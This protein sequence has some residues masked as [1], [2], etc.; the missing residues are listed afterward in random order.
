MIKKQNGFTLIEILVVIAIICILAA[1]L[2]INL[3]PLINGSKEKTSNAKIL[4]MAKSL[5]S[6]YADHSRYPQDKSSFSSNVF[7]SELKGDPLSDPPKKEYYP[8]KSHE[9]GSNGEWM[10]HLGY[11]YY[12]RNNQQHNYSSR[13]PPPPE[14]RNIT[15]YD[16]WSKDAHTPEEVTDPIQISLKTKV[17]NWD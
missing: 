4:E 5:E 8:F 13:N 7:V 14:A 16:L 10:S 6:Y 3:P 17:N 15:R 1:A 2:M 11:P 12:Y 9:I